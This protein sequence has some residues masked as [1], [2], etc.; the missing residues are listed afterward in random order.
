MIV[1]SDKPEAMN[2]SD[3]KLRIL[4]VTSDK[5]PPFRP[6]ARVIF[7]EELSTRGHVIDW[8]IQAERNCNRSYQ[9]RYGKGTAYIAATDD[10]TSRGR[11]LRK[12][13]L[14]FINDLRMFN[15]VRRERYDLVQAKDKYLGALLAI[16]ASKLGK[17][18]FTYWLAYPH[19][20]ASLYESRENTARYR[21]FCLFR[22]YFYKFV[23]YK[24][25]LPA[26]DHIFVQSEQMKQDI[27]REGIPL[28]KM[29]P[30]PGSLSMADIPLSAGPWK[31]SKDGPQIVYLGTL[32]RARHL[33]FIVRVHAKVMQAHPDARLILVG[34]GDMPEDERLLINE[35][36]RLGI[37]KSIVFTGHLPMSEASEYIR[38][39]DVCVSPYYPTPILNSTSPTKLI[40]YMAMGKATV[41]N[42][43][44]EQS[45]V[46]SESGAGLCVPWDESAFSEAIITLLNNPEM[47]REMGA[48]G[49]SYVEGHRTN[50]LMADRVEDQYLHICNRHHDPVNQDAAGS[51]S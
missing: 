11:R 9:T 44:P 4:L 18:R 30:V 39:A 3:R 42:D 50:R 46:I 40:E 45:L 7:G 51:C 36:E 2:N 22:G 48:R 49:R 14:D 17:A 12:Y 38:H 1:T 15:L 28:A 37:R 41:G 5:Y 20:E 31:E 32:R 19:A 16:L 47:A 34:K 29:T 35:A 26:A 25:I 27:A 23:L 8:L 6:A 24:I 43:H 13:L 21:Y 10:G 33:D